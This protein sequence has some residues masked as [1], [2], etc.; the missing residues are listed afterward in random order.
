MQHA[1]RIAIHSRRYPPAEL[2]GAGAAQAGGRWNSVGRPVVYAS[3]TIALACL[4]TLVHTNIDSLPL[5]RRLIRIDIPDDVWKSRERMIEPYPLGWDE[6]PAGLASTVLGDAWLAPA[7]SAILEVP[8][9]IV[10]EERNILINPLH[11]DARRI[12][13]IDLRRWDYDDRL[14]TFR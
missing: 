1:W 4:E 13:G 6:Q 11:A 8:S 9:V 12:V 10:P 2:T 14:G 5:P 3:N 7:R